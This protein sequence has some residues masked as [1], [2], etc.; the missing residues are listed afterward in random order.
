MIGI[1][2]FLLLDR[3]HAPQSRSCQQDSK[4]I[5]DIKFWATCLQELHEGV[6]VDGQTTSGGFTP[7]FFCVFTSFKSFFVF[8]YDRKSEEV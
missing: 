1:K 6:S 7:G 3:V 5:E 4:E 8:G 2:I